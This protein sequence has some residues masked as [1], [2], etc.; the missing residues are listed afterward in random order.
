MLLTKKGILKIALMVVCYVLLGTVC[1]ILSLVFKHMGFP[2]EFLLIIGIVLYVLCV[3]MVLWGRFAEGKG[4]LI[5]LGNKLVREE[6]K[7]AEFLREYE[8][9][10]NADDLVINK[11][12]V[13]VLQPVMIAYD[14]LDDRENALATANEMIAGSQGAKKT[15]ATL[16]KTSLLFS[17]GQT[18]EAEALFVEAQ[19]QKLNY[20]CNVLVDGIFKSDRAIAVGDYSTAETYLLKLLAPTRPKPDNLTKVL[21]HYQLGEVYE[22][23]EQPDKALAHYRYC[24]EFGGETAIKKSAVEKLQQMK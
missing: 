6:L 20:M 9:V 8:K 14:I 13:E 22:K 2:G 1:V 3:L 19:K 15:L 12:S 10:K 5:G 18:E 16:F 24:A 21:A 23:L 11:P 17:Y 4:I 7:P